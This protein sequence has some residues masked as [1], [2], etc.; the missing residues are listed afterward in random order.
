MVRRLVA[1]RRDEGGE[2]GYAITLLDV[3]TPR[4]QLGVGL[5]FMGLDAN[6]PLMPAGPVL[7]AAGS[8]SFDV[9]PSGH[10]QLSVAF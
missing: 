9:A 3:L 2:L 5:F 7:H 1:L 4:P 10:V 6:V 8:S